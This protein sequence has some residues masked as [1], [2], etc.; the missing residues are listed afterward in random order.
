MDSKL[1]EKRVVNFITDL[2][3]PI[4]VL[5][6]TSEDYYRKPSIGCFDYIKSQILGKSTID[7]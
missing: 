4:T 1:I 5:L 7:S 3:I 6:A 2:N